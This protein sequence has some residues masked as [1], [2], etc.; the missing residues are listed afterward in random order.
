MSS[1]HS[2][3]EPAL[4]VKSSLIDGKR[5]WKK[6]RICDSENEAIEFVKRVKKSFA[7]AR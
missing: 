1:A 5:S 7:G 3:N 2:N 6:V 4:E